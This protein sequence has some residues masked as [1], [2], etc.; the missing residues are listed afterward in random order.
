MPRPCKWIRSVSRSACLIDVSD[1]KRL[2]VLTRMFFHDMLNTAGGIRGWAEL[3]REQA[4]AES[5]QEHEL[6]DLQLLAD[7]LVEEIQSQ[8]DLV[9]A[10][11]GDLEPEFAPL[12]VEEFLHR[13]TV[14]H[15]ASVGCPR[16]TFGVGG[17][18]GRQ[19]DHGRSDSWDVFWGI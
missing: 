13:L 19:S 16:A 11:T 15:S 4:P 1:E 7:Q 6:S 14:L 3:L 17:G 10:E 8:R 9:Y 5:Q 2:S 18:L 12:R